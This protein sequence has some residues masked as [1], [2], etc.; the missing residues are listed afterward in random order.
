MDQINEAQSKKMQS[1][2]ALHRNAYGRAIRGEVSS[3]RCIK[4]FCLSCQM[5]DMKEVANCAAWDCPLFT[6]RPYQKKRTAK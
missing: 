6:K 5:W 4:Q 2:P 3:L 1:V